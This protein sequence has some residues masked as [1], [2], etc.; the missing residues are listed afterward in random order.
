MLFRSTCPSVVDAVL[1]GDGMEYLTA[2]L[3]TPDRPTAQDEV[4]QEARAYADEHLAET[5]RPERFIVLVDDKE[6]RERYFTV[7]GRPRRQLIFDE[8]VQAAPAPIP[9]H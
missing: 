3:L 5:D 8:I 7:T 2:V 9:A 6:L 1:F 4:E